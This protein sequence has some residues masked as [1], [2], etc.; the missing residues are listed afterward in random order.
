[1]TENFNV[2]VQVQDDRLALKSLPIYIIKS[3]STGVL[4]TVQPFRPPKLSGQPA[5]AIRRQLSAQRRHSS[6]GRRIISS[7]ASRSQSFGATGAHLGAH[8]AGS[9]VQLGPAQH[10]VGARGA[11]LPAV[12][13]QPDVTRLGVSSPLVETMDHRLHAARVA[14]GTVVYTLLHLAGVRVCHGGHVVLPGYSELAGLFGSASPHAGPRGQPSNP[15]NQAD[16]SAS[17]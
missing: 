14:A 15:E 2:F 3:F 10:E 5:V 1:L 7:S 8:L 13:Q 17:P 9:R 11:D 4:G 12:R 16:G 6:A